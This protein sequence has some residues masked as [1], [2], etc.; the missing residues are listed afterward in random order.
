VTS[1]VKILQPV[2]ERF[3]HFFG[4]SAHFVLKVEGLFFNGF[5]LFEPK[6]LG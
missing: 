4:V 5:D 1:E 6:D 3:G 2:L